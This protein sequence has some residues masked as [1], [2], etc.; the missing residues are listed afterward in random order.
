M[1]ERLKYMTKPE[2][3]MKISKET[4]IAK[5]DVELIVNEVFDN[6]VNTVVSG[7]EIAIH[8]FGKFTPKTRA[9]RDGINPK[10][11]EAIHIEEKKTVGFKAAK[12]FK[13]KF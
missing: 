7:E 5:T 1:K 8:A 3:I 11:Q 13:D 10:T 6:I 2:L 12:A 9:A 4:E